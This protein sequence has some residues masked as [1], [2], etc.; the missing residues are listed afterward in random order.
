MGFDH[1]TQPPSDIMAGGA[2]DL[3]RICIRCLDSIYRNKGKAQFTVSS[4]SLP[5]GH[6]KGIL[7]LND[8]PLLE[9]HFHTKEE[10]RTQGWELIKGLKELLRLR[11]APPYLGVGQET[12]E[13]IIK[14]R[15]MGAMR[16]GEGML[17][18]ELS[19]DP[20]TGKWE[21]LVI[22]TSPLG[23]MILVSC[24]VDAPSDASPEVRAFD[25]ITAVCVIC[26]IPGE[27]ALAPSPTP[28]M[29]METL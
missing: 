14:G 17:S 16:P 29:K 28:L 4:E 25:F 12:L 15:A 13:T 20:T 6:F 27:G 11:E 3:A 24:P 9:R 2:S 7:F 8:E 26:T 21:T 18:Y 22:E 1:D 23:V 19:I 10:I 5:C